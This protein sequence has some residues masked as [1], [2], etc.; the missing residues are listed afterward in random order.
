[1]NWSEAGRK[2]PKHREQQLRAATGRLGAPRRP[3]RS[4]LAPIV[5]SALV[6][7]AVA[8]V[9]LIMLHRRHGQRVIAAPALAATA[10]TPLPSVATARAELLA[11][12]AVLR[13]GHPAHVRRQDLPYYL[14]PLPRSAPEGAYQPGQGR[15]DRPLVR[16]VRIGG[17]RVGLL[18]ITWRPTPRSKRTEGLVLTLRAPVTRGPASGIAQPIENGIDTRSRYLFTLPAPAAIRT[19]GMTLSAPRPASVREMVADGSTEVLVV[20]PD[21]VTSVRLSSFALAGRTSTLGM[22]AATAAVHDNVALVPITG[23][24]LQRLHIPARSL[25]RHLFFARIQPHPCRTTFA[26]YSLPATAQMVWTNA[27]RLAVNTVA[28]PIHLF[29]STDH[30]VFPRPI[31]PAPQAPADAH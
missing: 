22:S 31:C 20:V 19:R 21:G 1:M 18:P 26:T 4:G 27:S 5:A 11:E 12:L 2:R 28:A 14:R 13:T 17:Y 23:V 9:A 24:R 30:P 16:T 25:G 29:A 15:L 10:V 6:A 7:V 8:G 3:A